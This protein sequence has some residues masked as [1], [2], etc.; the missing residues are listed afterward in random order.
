VSPYNVMFVSQITNTKDACS[1]ISGNPMAC[2][3]S[4]LSLSLSL[5]LSLLFLS[6]LL[7]S[8]LR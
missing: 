8:P 5:S 2:P 7:S 4:G 6:S 1:S 3:A